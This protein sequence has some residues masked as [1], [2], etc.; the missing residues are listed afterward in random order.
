[1]PGGVL[2][3]LA[4]HAVRGCLDGSGEAAV[5]ELVDVDLDRRQFAEFLDRVGE[6]RRC[7]GGGEEAVRD[8]ADGGEGVGECALGGKLTIQSPL[9]GGTRIEAEIPCA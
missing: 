3:G 1:M 8:G 9:G 6:P 7:Q 4:D 2:D 5:G